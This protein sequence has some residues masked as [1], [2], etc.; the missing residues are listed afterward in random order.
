MYKFWVKLMMQ[1]FYLSSPGCF[2]ESHFKIIYTLKY[3]STEAVVISTYQLM[4]SVAEKLWVA[5]CFVPHAKYVKGRANS[6]SR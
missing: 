6:N 4:C 3:F 2:T 5:P 1:V